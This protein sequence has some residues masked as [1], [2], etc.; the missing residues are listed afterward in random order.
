VSGPA[1]ALL[2]HVA[3]P[4]RVER[5]Y[6]PLL[7]WCLALARPGTP[8]VLGINGPQGAGKSTLAEALVVGL[9]ASGR[10]ALAVSVDDFYLTHAEQQALAAAHP[11]NP[12]MEHRGY[13]G[14]HDVALGRVT[15]EALRA[16]APVAV[17][18]YD[19]S[20]FEGRGDRRPRARWL[21]VA[22]PWD[23]IIVEGWML[24]FRPVATPPPALAATNALLAAYEAW[25]VLLDATILLEPVSLDDIVAWRIESEG[26]RR[27]RGEPAL[28]EDDARDYILRFLPAYE[29]WLPGLLAR[30]PGRASRRVRL[31]SDRMP[32]EPPGGSGAG[33]PRSGSTVGQSGPAEHP[34]TTRRPALRVEPRAPGADAVRVEG[35][36]ETLVVEEPLEIRVDGEPAAITMRTPG[37]DFDLV[38]G[39]LAAEGVIDG[40][41][42]LRA[43]AEVAENT[44]DVR[45][46]EGVPPARAR[47]ADRALYAT[48]AC[49]VCGK[50]S[51]DR[52]KRPGAAGLVAWQPRDEVLAG[53]PGRLRAAQSAWRHTGGLHAA[54]LFDV[55]G[56]LRHVREDV[57]RHNAVDKVL[58]ARLRADRDADADDG[59]PVGLV[60][61]SR[62]GFEIVQKVAAARI[63]VLVTMGAATSLA[64]D[65]ARH[66]GVLLV[67]WLRED[68]W[69]VFRPG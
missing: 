64:V 47:S 45:L 27:A 19:K 62:A 54:A 50:A 7:E 55:D 4:A 13:P 58:G 30:P 26:A 15:I 69:V 2:R 67:T 39:F 35:G 57:G 8:L 6:L 41:D 65:A 24:G 29:T 53:L 1:D 12:T 17:P 10:R 33:A 43:I 11:G 68:R 66:A 59:T 44:V 56:A 32:V 61:T 3:D 28:S 21:D 34:G 23:V 40:I 14:T 60:A 42:D 16:G 25:T 20:A 18:R 49:G 51:L 46:A 31:G 63:P 5:Y 38:V 22:G 36:D 37:D 52:L 9:G 48:S